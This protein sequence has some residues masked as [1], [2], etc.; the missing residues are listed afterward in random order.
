[1]ARISLFMPPLALIR[2]LVVCVFYG[3]VLDHPRWINHTHSALCSLHPGILLS[4]LDRKHKKAKT[5]SSKLL[6]LVDV[7]AF[8]RRVVY[9]LTLLDL[10]PSSSL[11]M[12]YCKLALNAWVRLWSLHMQSERSWYCQ[13]RHITSFHV[14]LFFFF[15]QIGVSVIIQQQCN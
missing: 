2:M 9:L 13:V 12:T 11:W 5:Q 10:K 4:W 15:L 7:T 14:N 6:L 3:I 1:M 8:S